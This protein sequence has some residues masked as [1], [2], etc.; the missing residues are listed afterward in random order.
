MQIDIQARPFSLTESLHHYS[1]R[2][3]RFALTRFEDHI[4]RIS[5][6]LSDVNGP[7]GG[8]DK[9]CRLQIV[10]AGKTSV[11]I[12]D[13]QANLHVAINRTI[14]RACR[15]LVRK[16]DRKQSRMH[17]SGTIALETSLSI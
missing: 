14:E 2:R 7:R 3:I 16:L 13:T 17:R 6:W 12:E 10:L 9:H 8:R 5:M 11:I 1:E 15:S 4:Q